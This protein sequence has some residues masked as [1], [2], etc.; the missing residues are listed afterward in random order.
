MPNNPFSSVQSFLGDAAKVA[1]TVNRT[2]T[3]I[4][5]AASN[6][7]SFVKQALLP[8]GAIPTFKSFLEAVVVSRDNN[9]WRVRLSVPSAYQGSPI[10]APLLETGNS[11]VFPFTPSII[12][13][14]TANYSSLSPV[15]SNYPF[16]IYQ[17]SEVNDIMITGDFYVENATDA[18]YWLAAIHFLRTITKMFYGETA[19]A[20]S[21]P[22]LSRLN[23]YGDFVFKDVPVVI[24]TFTVEFAQDVDYIKTKVPN[25]DAEN[26]VPA[27]SIISVTVVPTYSRDTVRQ[28]SLDKF[29]NGSY[30]LDTN[31]RGFI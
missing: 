11:M 31:R 19:D 12:M 28:F 7:Y 25:S 4:R 23:G 29:V 2:V 14:H 26:F 20:G 24:K 10:L 3:D 21:P 18:E 15:H 17:N 1:N 13:Q 9:D 30:I 8:K 27:H 22:P 16:P 5:N 6:P